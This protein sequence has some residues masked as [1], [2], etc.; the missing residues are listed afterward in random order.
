MS[1][2][3]LN[4]QVSPTFKRHHYQLYGWIFIPLRLQSITILSYIIL[5]IVLAA[6]HY[7]IYDESY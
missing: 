2:F 4:L 5:Q 1:W 6:V 3:R 7:P